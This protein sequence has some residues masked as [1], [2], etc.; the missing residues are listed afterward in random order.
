MKLT[1]KQEKILAFIKQYIQKN[2]YAP[3]QR[4]IQQALGIKSDS[5]LNYVLTKL[6]TAGSIKRSKQKS[7]NNI[8]LL[9][10][11]FSM[12]LLGKIA[13]GKPIEAINNHEEISITEKLLGDNRYLLEVKGD[14]MIEDN[15]CDGDWVICERGDNFANG[16][17]VVALINQ[18]EATLKRFFY[19]NNGMVCL[20]PA[21]KNYQPQYFPAD[22]VT[23]QGKFIGLIRLQKK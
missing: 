10:S 5:F 16:T 2:Q 9:T 20:K 23:V 8:E 6:E 4:E 7:R 11:P 1:I 19:E 18:N 3:T 13:A 17:I 22:T 15:I 21:N 14:S 12:P